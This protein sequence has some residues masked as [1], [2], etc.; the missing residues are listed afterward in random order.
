MIILLCATLSGAMF[1]LSQ[2]WND[3]WALAWTAPVPL[4]W[5]AYGTAPRWQLFVASLAAFAAG[6]LYMV[7]SYGAA[8]IVTELAMML[9]LGSLF[10]GAILFARWVWRRLPVW[11]SLLA[12]PALWT[13][14]EYGVSLVSPHGSWGAFG[15]SQMSFPAAIQ[16]AALF[17]LYAVTFILC[18]FANTL[19]LLARGAKTAGGVGFAACAASIIFGV[20]QLA[21]P[22]APVVRV[23][24]LA[25]EGQAYMKA[26]HTGDVAA[27]LSVTRGYSVAIRAEA[28]L[29]PVAG[30]IYGVWAS[31]IPGKALSLSAT[32]DSHDT[33]SGTKMFCSGAGLIDRALITTGV[34][35]AP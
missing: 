31:E 18:L 5:L 25:D 23:A 29:P 12:F 11:A 15:Y 14:I 32:A 9:G 27:A 16:I 26:F 19:A 17:G 1:Y 6:Q 30:A 35:V 33:L 4:L 13:A 3:V 10:A 28:G 7:F 8:L 21:A 2:G 20:T 22:R 24:A 34:V